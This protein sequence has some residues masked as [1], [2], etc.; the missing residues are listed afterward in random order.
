MNTTP[1]SRPTPEEGAQPIFSAP[2]ELR[3]GGGEM[4]EWILGRLPISRKQIIEFS[5]GEGSTTRRLLRHNPAGYLGIHHPGTTDGSPTSTGLQNLINRANARGTLQ[6]RKEPPN[7]LLSAD[8]RNTGLPAA[9][10]DVVLSE[11]FLSHNPEDEKL[12][13]L[14]EAGRLLRPGGFFALHEAILR[15]DDLDPALIAT[16]REELSQLLG[17][18]AHPLSGA[19]WAELIEKAGFALVEKRVSDLPLAE[20]G[21]GLGALAHTALKLLRRARKSEENIDHHRNFGAIALILTL[22]E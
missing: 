11:S 15:P 16:R 10:A 2:R 8:L 21:Q 1:P 14:R 5:P 7:R 4:T 13:V 22:K 9:S 12:R 19:G 20:P 17:A 18:E 3:P 6:G